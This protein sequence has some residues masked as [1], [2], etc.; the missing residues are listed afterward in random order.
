MT[1]RSSKIHFLQVV[2]SQEVK[3]FSRIAMT[4]IFFSS[5]S[6]N[7]ILSEYIKNGAQNGAPECQFCIDWKKFNL[8]FTWILRV[9]LAP[10][11]GYRSSVLSSFMYVEMCTR[12][13]FF[14]PKHKIEVL[15]DIQ[16]C[17]SKKHGFFKFSGQ[18]PAILQFWELRFELQGL[19]NDTIIKFRKKWTFS[20]F[21]IFA[22]NAP[23]WT[24]NRL[25]WN[26]IRFLTMCM[27][28][29][30]YLFFPEFLQYS[31]PNAAWNFG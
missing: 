14:N 30:I 25:V 3:K 10:G 23:V 27:K 29:D 16:P 7:F 1:I 12:V 5:E 17:R 21:I 9:F 22:Q 26:G 8:N 15:N 31:A 28:L 4:L 20:V 13:I 24:Y 11:Q 6:W 2:G 18:S 19:E